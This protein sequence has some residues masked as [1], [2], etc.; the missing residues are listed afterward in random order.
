[1]RITTVRILVQIF[2]FSLFLFFCF[3]T[4]FSYLKGYPVSLFLEADPL[5][6]I[7]TAITTHTV[8][9][10]L[11]WSLVLIIPTFILGRFFCNWICP[12]GILHQFTGWLFNNR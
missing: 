3:V 2:F 1:M 10:G 4:E 6:G 7:A 11:L 9:K 8:Y 5:V 12:Y